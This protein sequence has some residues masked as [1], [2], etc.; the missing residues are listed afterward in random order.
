MGVDSQQ[1]EGVHYIVWHPRIID[2]VMETKQRGRVGSSDL[3]GRAFP[4]KTGESADA[5]LGR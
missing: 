3:E 2:E 5:L 1:G 4:F